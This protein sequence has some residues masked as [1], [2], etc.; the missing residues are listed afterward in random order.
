MSYVIYHKETTRYLKSH[1]GVKTDKTYFA[2]LAAAKSALTREVN[3]GAVKREDFDITDNINFPYIEKM[4]TVKNLMTGK[5]VLQSVNTP[6]CC[7]VSSEQYWS[8]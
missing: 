2:S 3:N 5:D 8:M 4:E 1:R 7:D 6:R